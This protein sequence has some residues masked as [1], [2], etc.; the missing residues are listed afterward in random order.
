MRTPATVSTGST[1]LTP[2]TGISTAVRITPVP[3]P[4]SPPTIAAKNAATPTQA[5]VAGSISTSERALA[6]VA[7]G[8]RRLGLGWP[9]GAAVE[10]HRDLVAGA[11]LR[12]GAALL[13]DQ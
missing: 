10:Q 11:E 4:P 6:D 12:I 5:I 8:H 1:A 13:V 2:M 9:C 3:N 7:F